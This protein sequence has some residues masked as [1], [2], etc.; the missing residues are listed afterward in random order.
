V[1]N[2]E[3]NDICSSLNIIRVIKPRRMG[4]V[5]HVACTGERKGGYSVIV[6]E[7]RGTSTTCKTRAQM[8]V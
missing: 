3:F 8:G 7:T 5:G 4:W 6:G 1:H 2:E